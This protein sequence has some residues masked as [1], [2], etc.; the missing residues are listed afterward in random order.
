MNL[1]E[2]AL[3]LSWGK[4]YGCVSTSQIVFES[5][6]RV[7]MYSLISHELPRIGQGILFACKFKIINI[8]PEDDLRSTVE[9]QTFPSKNTLKTKTQHCFGILLF[10]LEARHG[11]A[12]YALKESAYWLLM[13]R[14]GPLALRQLDSNDWAFLSIHALEKDR[15]GVG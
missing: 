9:I 12:I 4:C 8:N 1:L 10:Q 5:F 7:Q 2:A 3:D 11:M 15:L 13:P 14:W 6:R